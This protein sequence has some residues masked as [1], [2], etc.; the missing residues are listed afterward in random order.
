MSKLVN[1]AKADK[2]LEAGMFYP[3]GYIVTGHQDEGAARTALQRLR[4]A[5]FGEQDLTL[6]KSD[7]MAAQAA[8]NLE[9]PAIFAAMGASV[10]V[11]QKQYD[12]ASEGCSF[13]LVKA[14]EDEDE[15][16]ALQALARE[17]LRYAVKYR[18]LVIENLLPKLPAAIPDPEPA[19]AR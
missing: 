6:V 16:N 15:E 13:L 14:P 19:R 5:G 9:H 3:T 2:P 17:P 12:M 8:H 7:D 4:E 10:A 18:R 11:R 1:Q